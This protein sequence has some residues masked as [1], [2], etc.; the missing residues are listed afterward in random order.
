M[1]DPVCLQQLLMPQ[2]REQY[3]HRK[4]FGSAV[5]SHLSK[6][7]INDIH[8]YLL[9]IKWKIPCFVYKQ[10]CLNNFSYLNTLWSQHVQISDFLLQLHAWDINLNCED[11]GLFTTIYLLHASLLLLLCSQFVF[12]GYIEQ[13]LVSK[14]CLVQITTDLN[15]DFCGCIFTH[16]N[17]NCHNFN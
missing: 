3:I 1:A 10:Y 11:F 12:C 6:P 2:D 4:Q 14:K 5:G 7:S 9:R 8:T 15:R 13:L 16:G 17:N